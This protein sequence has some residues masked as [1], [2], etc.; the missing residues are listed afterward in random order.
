MR[1][2]IQRAAGA[3]CVI[4]G[5]VHSQIGRGYLVLIGIETGDTEEDADYL[6]GK[7]ANLRVL[8]D[9]EG[10]LNL[11]PLQT[12]AEILLVSQ[13]TLSAD[14]RKGNR[15]SFTAA[16][17]PGEA[18]PLYEY[19]ADRLRGLGVSRVATGVFGADMQLQFTND[20]PVTI[21]MDTR[22]MR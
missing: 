20:G 9:G 5:E 13:F 15:P 11:S 7:V 16:M 21:W 19:F 3:Q 10:K 17:A 1:A 22:T 12:G 2:L 4:A 18:E 8:A 14:C 6:A